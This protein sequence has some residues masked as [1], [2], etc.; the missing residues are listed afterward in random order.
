M[1]AA[2][3]FFKQL[4]YICGQV[5]RCTIRRLCSSLLAVDHYSN[6]FANTKWEIKD[7][8]MDNASKA[9]QLLCKDLKDFKKRLDAIAESLPYQ[10]PY[11]GA[12]GRLMTQPP[13]QLQVWQKLLGNIF[14]MLV[15]G[16][17]R[18]KKASMAGRALMMLDLRTLQMTLEECTGI[19]NLNRWPA[20]IFAEEYI[21]AFYL[22]TGARL[23]E[24]IKEIRERNIQYSKQ[25]LRA[26]VELGMIRDTITD[27]K[28]RATIIADAEE[29]MFGSRPAEVALSPSP[30]RSDD[31]REKDDAR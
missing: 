11:S 28:Q 12:G 21:R 2:Q 16:I 31:R 19:K 23:L 20:Y 26:I 6:Q 9:M 13:A 17:S 14:I 24:W 18:A 30:D 22:D 25:H 7:S 4:D 15:D 1:G 5:N 27:R 10:S 3:G 29:A 8:E